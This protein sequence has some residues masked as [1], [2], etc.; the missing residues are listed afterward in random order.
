[1]GF[2]FKCTVSSVHKRAALFVNM[3]HWSIHNIHLILTQVIWSASLERIHQM[4]WLSFGKCCNMSVP[5][6]CWLK[7][8]CVTPRLRF[9]ITVCCWRGAGEVETSVPGAHWQNFPL[10]GHATDATLCFQTVT[11]DCLLLENHELNNSFLYWKGKCQGQ[12]Y[13]RLTVN[14]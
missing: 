14:I 4:Y 11:I 6:F 3:F 7:H 10:P 1:M 2:F 8:S 12:G 5:S 13:E 9:G